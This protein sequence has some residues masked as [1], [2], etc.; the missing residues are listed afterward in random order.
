MGV[1][2]VGLCWGLSVWREEGQWV[3]VFWGVHWLGLC[4]VA[5]WE[6]VDP[7]GNLD[8]SLDGAGML[9]ALGVEGRRGVA[10]W[11]DLER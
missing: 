3:E 4:V 11:V 2:E 10:P 7:C 5:G 1:E 6:E 8:W 9:L